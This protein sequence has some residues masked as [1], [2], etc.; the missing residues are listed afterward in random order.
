[1]GST[2][3][4]STHNLIQTFI[5]KSRHISHLIAQ[6]FNT[7][8]NGLPGN[9][10]QLWKSV[11]QS[12][13]YD[14]LIGLALLT[15]SSDSG[16]E[17]YLTDRFLNCFYFLGAMGTY[18]TFYLARLYPLPATTQ[19]LLSSP[20]FPQISP[21]NPFF[22][23]TTKIMSTGFSGNPPDGTGGNVFVQVRFYQTCPLTIFHA[24]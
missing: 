15:E 23:T 19:Y 17:Q 13:G 5:P 21:F 1:M 24:E 18:A 9:D 3:Q 20:F 14:F 2:Q 12:H 16:N 10:G 8:V 22:N 7:S 4:I 11:V 6:S